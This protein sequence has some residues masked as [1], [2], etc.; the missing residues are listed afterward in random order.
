MAYGQPC[1]LPGPGYLICK[2]GMR[3]GSPRPLPGL[4]EIQR[5]AHSSLEFLEIMIWTG[6][7]FFLPPLS[8]VILMANTLTGERY[9][10]LD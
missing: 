10:K 6:A 3:V 8:T 1:P 4:S 2:K 9:F 5:E 7:D